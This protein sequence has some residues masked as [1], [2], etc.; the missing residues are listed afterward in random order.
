MPALHIQ[1]LAEPDPGELA[2][3]AGQ[4]TQV[5]ALVAPTSAE[6]VPALHNAQAPLPVATLCFPAWQGE[7]AAPLGPVL[8]AL[9]MHAV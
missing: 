4:F 9:Q 2:E 8:P 7:H 6:Y 3:F 5:F 1:E